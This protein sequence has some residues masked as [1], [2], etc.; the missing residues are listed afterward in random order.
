MDIL[1]QAI[2]DGYLLHGSQ[3]LLRGHLEP[4]LANFVT[5]ETDVV[6]DQAW[7][8]ATSHIEVAIAAAVFHPG[9]GKSRTWSF[10]SPETGRVQIF[11]GENVTLKKGYVYILSPESF[12]AKE[13]EPGTYTTIVPVKPI[14]RIVVTPQDLLDLQSEF[15]FTLDIR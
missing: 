3:H 8:Y 11:G 9:M 13:Q 12:K 5:K 1:T 15:G 7:L 10:T 2:K 14:Q 6:E 4:R